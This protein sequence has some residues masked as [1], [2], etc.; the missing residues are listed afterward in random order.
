MILVKFLN[1][2]FKSKFIYF[3]NFIRRNKKFEKKKKMNKNNL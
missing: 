1:K 2:K 3:L